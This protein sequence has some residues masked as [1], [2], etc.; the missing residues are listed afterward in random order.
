MYASVARRKDAQ[1]PSQVRGRRLGDLWSLLKGPLNAS[2]VVAALAK[3]IKYVN[4]TC[5]RHWPELLEHGQVF[6]GASVVPD[7]GRSLRS[8]MD[9]VVQQNLVVIDK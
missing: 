4:E 8:L 7:E 5:Y 6:G 3:R 1:P 9:A 2:L